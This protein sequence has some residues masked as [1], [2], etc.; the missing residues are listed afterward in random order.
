[1]LYKW[2]S[3]ILVSSLHCFPVSA[4]ITVCPLFAYTLD[5]FPP[6]DFMLY[7]PYVSHHPCTS[8]FFSFHRCTPFIHS[9]EYIC[10]ESAH[11]TVSIYPSSS[12]FKGLFPA[13]VYAPFLP[14]TSLYCLQY[15]LLPW[16]NILKVNRTQFCLAFLSHVFTFFFTKIMHTVLRWV[17]SVGFSFS[18]HTYIYTYITEQPLSAT[19]IDSY[20][21]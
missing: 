17:V 13:V 16:C 8:I 19:H 4:P 20:G 15:I 18:L 3:R 9:Q 1:M 2:C 12:S 7:Y 14:G 6:T 11:S 21:L 10:L 5:L